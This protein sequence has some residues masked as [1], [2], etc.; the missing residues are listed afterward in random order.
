MS[1]DWSDDNTT[2]LTELFVQQVRAGNRP[3]KHLLKMLMR[4]LRRILKSEQ[5]WSTPGSN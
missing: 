5:A 2:I 3:D 1:A 4:K